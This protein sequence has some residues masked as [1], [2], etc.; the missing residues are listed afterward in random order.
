MP[1]RRYNWPQLFAEFEASGQ[2]QTDFCKQLAI[3]P[4]YF[5]ARWNKRKT[6]SSGDA[7]TQLRL[8]APTLPEGFVLSVG[9]CSVQCSERVSTVKLA[10]LI[11][12]LA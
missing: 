8:K 2:S 11:K 9:R 12:A 5:S 4:S 3:D 6:A 10:E 7:F 1:N